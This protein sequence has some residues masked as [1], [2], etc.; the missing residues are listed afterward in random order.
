M[1]CPLHWPSLP[2]LCP[3]GGMCLGGCVQRVYRGRHP[4]DPEAD[5]PRTQRQTP[6]NPEADNHPPQT[7][8]RTPPVNRMT[9][10]SRR[11]SHLL[12][13]TNSITVRNF[14][15]CTSD[16]IFNIPFLISHISQ[17][18]TLERYDVILTGSPG[19]GPTKSGDVITAGI[20]D[21]VNVDLKTG[22]I[23]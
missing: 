9:D 23:S 15:G 22:M 20:D 14:T 17:T 19:I 16:M 2:G 21:V 8:G 10:S 4:P 3:G 18:F 12:I 5:I 1:Y 7:Q 6:L 13:S 11:E